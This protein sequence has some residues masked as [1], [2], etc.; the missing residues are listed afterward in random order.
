MLY[1]QSRR[2]AADN[3]AAHCLTFAAEFV[4]ICLSV[5]GEAK[6]RRT[7]ERR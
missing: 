1:P 4:G 6:E 2:N 5:R 7:R 3:R